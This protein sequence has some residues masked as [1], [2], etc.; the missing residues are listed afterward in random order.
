M[1]DCNTHADRGHR[2]ADLGAPTRVQPP[3]APLRHA[4]IGLGEAVRSE[5]V[6]DLNQLLVDTVVLRDL[7]TKHRWQVSGATAAPLRHLFAAHGAQLERLVDT[8]ADR[9]HA[10]GGVATPMPSDVSE[11][12]RIDRPPAAREDPA[13]QM[14][15]LAMAHEAIL[16]L[17][18]RAA[19]TAGEN[20]D[21]GT[22][23][24]IVSDLIRTNERQVGRV[25]D[26]LV[27]T[28]LQGT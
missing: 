24:V 13:V 26:H 9:V 21:E 25:A 19:M 16:V 14:T 20:D 4:F 23:A 8:L 1:D 10:L 17:A 6:G 7:Y 5:G 15:R 22:R 27:P 3:D 18:R 11:R 2:L 28:N 12:T